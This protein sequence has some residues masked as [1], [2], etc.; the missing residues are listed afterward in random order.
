M[1]L[2]KESVVLAVVAVA[3]M[4]SSL[5]ADALDSLAHNKHS[6]E[7]CAHGVAKP[8]RWVGTCTKCGD[9]QTITSLTKPVD[10]T[11][12]RGVPGGTCKG[13]VIW[14]SED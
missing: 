1:K 10:N 8:K 7:V 14:V 4:L 9:T 12:N 11:C 5:A 2:S 6:I 13:V 3:T